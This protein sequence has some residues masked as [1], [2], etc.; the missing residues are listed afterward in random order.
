MTKAKTAGNRGREGAVCPVLLF[1]EEAV[2]GGLPDLLHRVQAGE[3][4]GVLFR[5]SKEKSEHIS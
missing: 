5:N 2:A 1:I 3:E 4:Y